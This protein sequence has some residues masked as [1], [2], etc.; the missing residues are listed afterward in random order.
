M[1]L[2]LQEQDDRLRRLINMGKERGYVLFDEV[3][4]ILPGETPTAAEVDRLFSAFEGHNIH[5]RED[6]PA[7]MP[8]SGFPGVA[9]PPKSETREDSDPARRG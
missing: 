8:G 9:E 5:L 2:V 1:S 4:E 6:V 3:N 7:E